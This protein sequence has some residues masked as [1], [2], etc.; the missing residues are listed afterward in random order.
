VG[1]LDLI[2]GT[3]TLFVIVPIIS[4]LVFTFLLK[5]V[6]KKPSNAFLFAADITTFFLIY[7]VYALFLVIWEYS[8]GSWIILIF[9]IILLLVVALF[10]LCNREIDIKKSLRIAWRFHF[11]LYFISHISLFLFGI[12]ERVIQGY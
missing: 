5:K 3:V 6:V 2:T 11:L 1:Q 8:I 4:L 7:S 12:I 10:W 9:F